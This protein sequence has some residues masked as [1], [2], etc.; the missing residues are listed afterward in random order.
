[1]KKTGKTFITGS[2]PA[3]FYLGDIPAGSIPEKGLSKL[4]LGLAVHFGKKNW[5]LPPDQIRKNK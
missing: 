4:L 2:L 5:P 1:M 3:S